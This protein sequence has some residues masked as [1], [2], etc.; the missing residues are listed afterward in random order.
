[1]VAVITNKQDGVA[2]SIRL[3]DRAAATRVAELTRSG[4]LSV[5][6]DAGSSLQRPLEKNNIVETCM[7]KE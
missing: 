4:P 2:S 5:A 6:E 1:M 3:V 7:N